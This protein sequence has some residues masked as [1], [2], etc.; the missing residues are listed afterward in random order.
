MLTPKTR[1]YRP[2]LTQDVNELLL[3]LGP[4]ANLIIINKYILFRLISFNELH[5]R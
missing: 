3:K 5:T 2:V 4:L 1:K